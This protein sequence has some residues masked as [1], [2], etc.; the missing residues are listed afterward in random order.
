MAERRDTIQYLAPTMAAYKMVDDEAI[1]PEEFAALAKSIAPV[2]C[3]EARA[4]CADL[5]QQT[6]RHCLL[7]S[8]ERL[9]QLG[10][11]MRSSSYVAPRTRRYLSEFAAFFEPQSPWVQY[12]LPSPDSASPGLTR[13]CRLRCIAMLMRWREVLLQV[14]EE[15]VDLLFQ[16][17][18]YITV[19]FRAFLAQHRLVG[20]ARRP[21]AG[22]TLCLRGRLTEE[23]FRSKWGG[24]SDVEVQYAIDRSVDQ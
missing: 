18:N 7:I 17:N 12:L 6:S 3:A 1:R 24:F 22:C 20:F 9:G 8:R 16:R 11:V 19:A 15:P 10:S 21:A 2:P 13:E 14:S 23:E 4:K 5:V